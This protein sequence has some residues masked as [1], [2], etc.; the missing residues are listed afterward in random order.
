MDARAW[1]HG[2]A[3]ALL[4]SACQPR[5]EGTLGNSALNPSTHAAFPI[6][7]AAHAGIDCNTCHGEFATFAEFSCL[8]G[9][10]AQ[11]ATDPSHDGFGGYGYDS[12]ACYRC[13]PAGS[14][15]GSLLDHSFPIGSTAV[16][17]DMACGNCHTDTSTR[18][19]FS[20]TTGC[21]A[22]IETDPLHQGIG[23]Y[24]YTSAA[25]LTCHPAGIAS[26][27][28]VSHDDFPI[29]AGT[30]HDLGCTQ[31]HTD[32]ADRK[33]L[34]KLACATCHLAIDATLIAKH[35]TTPSNPRI[36]V[37]ASE[38][39]GTNPRTCLRCHADA[40]VD[41]TSGHSKSSPCADEGTPPHE[42]AGCTQCHS[43][44]RVD[45]AYAADFTVTPPP[46]CAQCHDNGQTCR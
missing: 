22:Q 27:A 1:R 37:K 3:V 43:S 10:H 18:R 6:E 24:A 8:A 17:H 15:E 13:H 9:C 30:A 38:I 14:A 28:M 36:K 40:Q 42:G 12:A 23:D 44:Y 19:V 46:G 34:T 45:K 35:T 2:M 21:H 11:S 4:V 29:G 41:R 26:G 39:S 31:C 5:N 20:C 33:N 32:P 16:H 7:A 25:C